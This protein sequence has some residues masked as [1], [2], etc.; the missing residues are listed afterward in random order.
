MCDAGARSARGAGD[1]GVAEARYV[2]PAQLVGI[3]VIHVDILL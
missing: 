3:Y 1:A 2:P